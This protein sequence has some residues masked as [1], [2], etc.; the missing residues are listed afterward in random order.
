M[1]ERDNMVVSDDSP[2]PYVYLYLFVVHDMRVLLPL[3]HFKEKVLDVLNVTP[4]EI[5]LNG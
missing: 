4:S 5:I 3:S 1:A 2:S